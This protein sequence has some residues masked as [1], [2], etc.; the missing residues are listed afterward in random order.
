VRTVTCDFTRNGYRLPT[1]AEWEKAARGG[2]TLPSGTNATPDRF[3]P[4][5]N[6]ALYLRIDG[7]LDGDPPFPFDLY[8]SLR[9][10]VGAPLNASR[11]FTGPIFGGSL[12]VGS[13]PAG[14]G[15]YGHDDLMGNIAEW[16]NDWF[17]AGYYS[18]SPDVDPHGPES[19]LP[20][21]DDFKVLRGDSWYGAYIPAMN[22]F[23]VEVGASKRRWATYHFSAPY[24]GF[25]V[26]R[27][28]S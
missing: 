10:D 6:D 4:W 2:L 16:C 26:A 3:F 5:G 8:G 21:I 11:P 24:L 17:G 14:R 20:S 15:P 1:E 27:T 28:S 12:P 22:A 23:S 19:V 9:A 13:F 7:N 25:R 18:D